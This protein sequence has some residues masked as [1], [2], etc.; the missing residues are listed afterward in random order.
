MAKLRVFVTR[1][2]PVE[3]WEQ[4]QS[5]A[6]VEIW[7]DEMPPPPDILE[8]KVTGIDGLACLLTDNIDAQLMDRAGPSLKV[9]SQ[10]AV[11]YNNIDV[12]A[13]TQRG[14]PV[15][16][17]PGVLTKTTAD[18]AWALLMAAA[19]R[20]VEGQRFVEAGKWRTWSPTLLMGSDVH[21]ATLGIIG[22]GRIGQAVAKRAQ[23]FD[24]RVI[25][26][27]PSTDLEIGKQYGAESCSLEEVLSESDFL[28]LHV[29]LNTETRHMIGTDEL[30]QMKPSSILINTAR[31]E[32]VDQ[33][34]L[35]QALAKKTIAYAALDVT[36]PE[37]ILMD[38]P[39]LSL[40]N[41]I[42]VPHIASSSRATRRKMAQM[43]LDNLI[44]GLKGE[45]L[46]NCV[47]PE[48]YK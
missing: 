9:I 7:P 3:D 42:V 15:G 34:A 23:G 2:L 43:A 27:N 21:G 44:T 41:C 45:Q 30:C 38:D 28:S 36:E 46:P 33:Q 37:P 1:Q 40:D 18:F 29:P 17:T 12:A 10:V 39:L 8:E 47:N 24:M 26:Y 35:Y 20:V 31:G 5:F 19:R 25:Y 4:I 13:A 16:N 22:F 32:V 14:I 48:V 6:E 11:G